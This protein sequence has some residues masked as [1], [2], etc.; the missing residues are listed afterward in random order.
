MKERIAYVHM[1]RD[2]EFTLA[3]RLTVVEDGAYSTCTFQY[4]RS[5]LLRSNAVPVDPVRLPLVEDSKTVFAGAAGGALF[6]GIQDALP[7]SWGRHV[8]DTAASAVGIVLTPLDYALYAGP[9]RVGALGFSDEQHAAPFSQIPPWGSSP[10]GELSLGEML[11]AADAVDDAEDLPVRLRRF[12][13]RGSSMGGARPK[14]AV[15][16]DGTAWIAKFGN[17]RE[18]WPTCRI[19][20]ATMRMA[21]A[22]GIPT[23]QT[24]VLT[25]FGERDILLVE[26]FDRAAGCR[27]PFISGLTL[28]GRTEAQSND[29]ASYADIATAMRQ[30][31]R[32][33]TL[34]KDLEDLFSRM[35]FNLCCNNYDDHLRNH[36]FLY[37]EQGKPG[38]RLTPAYDVVPQV[39]QDDG[40]RMLHLGVG[41][42][43]RL[44]T[45]ENAL[46][47]S[48]YF[49]LSREKAAV[50]AERVHSFVQNNWEK[51]LLE[52][53]VKRKLLPA[54]AD[55]FVRSP[56][57][58][59]DDSESPR[60]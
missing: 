18:A 20:H 25:V 51:H 33:D 46:S 32:A 57:V 24:K 26:R 1:H 38:W 6:G 48:E 53:G 56:E 7:D 55:C 54:I 58:E 14:A 2:G 27:I 29:V 11:E 49:G 19:E 60:P 52:A 42:Q 40:L 44:A 22:C 37:D 16:L 35:V 21:H 9:E 3:G 39:P 45:I 36:G 23:P 10:G 13:V 43:G 28:L 30:F 5:Y 31:C 8:L 41:R 47:E 50:I 34:S 12:F 15:E 4:A 17:Q 59:P